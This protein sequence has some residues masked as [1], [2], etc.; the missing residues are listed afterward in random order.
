MSRYLYKIT[1][2]LAII[3]VVYNIVIRGINFDLLR[4]FSL[5]ISLVIFLIVSTLY[6]KKNVIFTPTYIVYFAV[7]FIIHNLSPYTYIDNRMMLDTIVR[8]PYARIPNDH[9][10]LYFSVFILVSFMLLLYLLIKKRGPLSKYTFKLE[11]NLYEAKDILIIALVL[12]PIQ[13]V[14]GST[15]RKL[16]IP[17]SVYFLTSYYMFKNVRNKFIYIIGATI[18]LFV[19][20]TQITWRFIAVQYIFPIL[21]AVI[22]YKGFTTLPRK[23]KNREKYLLIFGV[24]GVVFYGIVSEMYKLGSLSSLSDLKNVF[25]NFPLLFN[26]LG[27][28]TYRI[29]GI[30]TVLGGNII[31]YVDNVGFFYGL[32]YIKSL[33]PVFGFDYI[34]LPTISAQLVGANYAQPGLVAEGYANFGY[35]GSVLNIFGVLILL[36]YLWKRFIYKQNMINFLLVVI[37]FTS[38][39]LDGGSFNS[40][41]FNIIII[42]ITFALRYLK[43]SVKGGI[44]NGYKV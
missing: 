20:M 25:L 27:R 18:S 4:N 14:I 2:Y 19:I 42:Y 5:L 24:I 9:Y 32:T 11:S 21:V 44:R 41:I 43:L 36:E 30:W 40:M 7:V 17:S 26:W 15:F 6:E 28:Q 10:K 13:F 8:V 3:L 39:L 31:D 12:L 37:P 33:S 22:I 35:V 34:S 1:R 29:F 23:I 38:V 16:L